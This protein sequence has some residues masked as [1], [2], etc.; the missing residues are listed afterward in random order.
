MEHLWGFQRKS[1]PFIHLFRC[2]LSTLSRKYIRVIQKRFKFGMNRCIDWY[3][4]IAI[5]SALLTNDKERILGLLHRF[6]DINI[7]TKCLTMGKWVVGFRIS[8]R[9]PNA[10]EM[11]HAWS[12]YQLGSHST[13]NSTTHYISNIK[14]MNRAFIELRYVDYLGRRA[15]NISQNEWLYG[16]FEIAIALTPK[17]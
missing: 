10:R 7:V 12:Y 4:I 3:T 2:H 11:R 5:P 17:P 16:S 13:L 1:I 6:S 14:T 8:F 9:D 15:L